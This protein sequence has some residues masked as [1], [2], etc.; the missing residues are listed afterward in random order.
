M[1]NDT[2]EWIHDIAS[3]VHELVLDPKTLQRFQEMI[4][5]RRAREV[6]E[7]KKQAEWLLKR[8]RHFKRLREFPA[9]H[10]WRTEGNPRKAPKPGWKWQS[11]LCITATDPETGQTSQEWVY[12]WVPPELASGSVPNI[13]RFLHDFFDDD[14]LLS[15][16]EKYTL[17]AM[18]HDAMLAERHQAIGPCEETTT[19][20]ESVIYGMY[21]KPDAIRRLTSQKCPVRVALADVKSDLASR[22]LPPPEDVKADLAG[23]ELPE[24]E[25]K[26]L[27]WRAL[28]LASAAAGALFGLFEA[29]VYGIPWAWL[30]DH[31]ATCGIQVAAGVFIP[32]ATLGWFVPPCR[33]FAW[34]TLLVGLGLLILSRL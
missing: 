26:R 18:I 5:Q 16:D 8:E 9:S 33:K 2:P 29:I 32:V 14:W 17:L 7:D 24:P 19:T 30:R 6:D 28:G 25:K 11:D 31:P 20:A 27:R 3:A 23:E 34:G 10:V 22:A 13:K 1:T 4:R 12:G 15:L 21:T